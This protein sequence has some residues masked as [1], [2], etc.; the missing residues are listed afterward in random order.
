M[1]TI[2]WQQLKTNLK[3]K[4]M[5]LEA[6][7]SMILKRKVGYGEMIQIDEEEEARSEKRHKMDIDASTM[8]SSSS[9]T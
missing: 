1:M 9:S 6:K 8:P 5:S 4:S 3:Q 2:L 7:K